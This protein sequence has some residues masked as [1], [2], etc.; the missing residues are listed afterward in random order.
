[1]SQYSTL[2]YRITGDGHPVIFL[3]GFLESITMWS[4]LDLESLPFQ[5]VLID[6]PGHG[7]S[8]L[9]DDSS[10]PSIDFYAQEV[11]NL[12]VE[13][14]ISNYHIVGHSMGGYIALKLK[15]LDSSCAKVV[16]LNSNFW[17]DE[18]L[19]KRDRVRV[20]DFALKAKN[21]F[22][23]EAIPGLFYRHDRTNT[24]IKD[25]TAEAKKIE[26]VAIAYASLAMRNRSNKRELLLANPKAFLIIQGEHD[27]LISLKK[28]QKELISKN[29]ELTLLGE[30]GH[31]A[32]VEE[33]EKVVIALL[34]FL[35]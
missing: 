15:E 26:G 20:A 33:P 11:K 34:R 12:L 16:L 23:N 27:P 7:L 17:E 21:L 10:I 4:Q 30:S 1:M 14:N 6:L 32:H 31:M 5:S 19:K 22:V 13:L 29:V 28:M 8:P 18:P 9:T 35:K 25:L 24:F 2:N 3:H